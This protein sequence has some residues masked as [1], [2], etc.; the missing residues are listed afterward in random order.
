MKRR[1]ALKAATV[2][3]VAGLAPTPLWADT[4]DTVGP[5]RLFDFAVLKGM[6][7]GLAAAPYQPV[8]ERL[9]KT[10][11]KLGY[12]QYQAIRFRPAHALWHGSGL[13]FQ[14]QFA[15]L[16]LY[17]KQPVHMYEVV[18]GQA[19]EI[20]YDP[21]MFAYGDSG[22][23]G[24]A[25][26][27]DTGFAGFRIQFHTDWQTDIAAFLGASYFR[28]IGAS[29]QY[30]LSAR[31]LAID[32]GLERPEEFP[33][34]KAFWFAQPAPG[35]TTLTLYALLDSASI[36]GAYRFTITPG[37]ELM[38]A[39]DAA[40][41][42][43]KAIERLGIAPGTSM[44]WCGENDKLACD[45][46]RPEI[47][48]S[49]GLSLWTGVGEWIWRPL[50]NPG[51]LRVNSYLDDNPRGFGLMQRDRNFDHYQDDGAWYN[52]RPSLWVEPRSDWGKGAVQLV[53][54][55]TRDETFDN[56][57]AFWNPAQKPQ[58][59][60]E[61]LLSYR[62]YW[63][64]Q[65]PAQSPL[66]R[67]VATR[68]GQGGVVGQKHSH[69]SRRFEIDFRGDGIERIPTAAGVEPVITV[70]RG[71]VELPSARPLFDAPEHAIGY[72]TIFDLAPTDDSTEPINMR[73]YLRL[74]GKPL[75]ETWLYQWTP[76]PVSQRHF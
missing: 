16:G 34:F 38:M 73:L 63:G 35:E 5:A 71:R 9:P 62:L 46:I 41:Y 2:C 51:V 14:I 33:L 48:D 32:T 10:L 54:I 76:P 43:R 15:H 12:D 50:N 21:A 1:D 55:P 45:D 53:E 70:S 58:P 40:L 47:H 69:Y 18:A 28:A 13:D 26:P 57:V 4:V 6:A 44:F 67:V 27:P 60:E 59:G 36:A 39:I 64:S 74:N 11:E 52:R 72:R 75:T 61:R 25:L 56:I 49:D 30:G 17:F 66:A 23:D 3:T 8:P 19:R 22:V 68:I 65:P 42:P 20:A 24:A 29:K 7:R 31:G 37:A